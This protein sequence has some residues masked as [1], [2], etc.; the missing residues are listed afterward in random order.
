MTSTYFKI[1]ISDKFKIVN[2]LSALIFFSSKPGTYAIDGVATDTLLKKETQRILVDVESDLIDV[3]IDC[4]SA[5]EYNVIFA[6]KFYYYQ[7]TN[8]TATVDFSDGR[9]VTFYTEGKV[10]RWDSQNKS[11]NRRLLVTIATTFIKFL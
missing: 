5:V 3:S 6:C 7:G 9:A 10:P 4:P 8:V 1:K 11:R 2:I